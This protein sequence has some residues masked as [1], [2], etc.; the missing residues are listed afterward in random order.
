MKPLFTIIAFALGI[1]L[2]IAQDTSA[3]IEGVRSA[4]Y[5]YINA[6]Y[7]ADT[8]LA[9]RSVH[10]SVRKTGF[11]FNDEKGNYSDQLEMPFD[12]L[13]RLAK[14]WNGTGK[15]ADENTPR[16]VEIF[17]VSD[18]TAAAKVTAIWGIDYISLMKIDDKWMIV[19]VLWQ[20]PPKFTVAEQ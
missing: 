4:C 13:V 12:Q 11:H 7:K 14:R 8:S 5:D 15:Q 6:F 3:D 17:E 19:N 18:K 9:Y 16:L 10:S 20:S 2:G 1:H